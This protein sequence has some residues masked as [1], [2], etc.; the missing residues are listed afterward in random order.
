LNRILSAFL[1][2]LAIVLILL[3]GI[4]I[5]ASGVENLAVGGV[6]VLIAALLLFYVYRSEKI[7]AAR[8]KVM[9][10]TF[11]VKMSGSGQLE[12]KQLTCR[13]C[14]APLADKDLRVVSGG[15]VVKCPYCGSVY[16]L[17]EAPKW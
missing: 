16:A 4:F 13:S 7:E 1:V 2:F 8:P 10:Q 15:V 11:N 5:I 3:G 14:G 17:E 6:F 9:N 12:Q